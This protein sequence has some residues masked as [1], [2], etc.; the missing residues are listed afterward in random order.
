MDDKEGK[1]LTEGVNEDDEVAAELEAALRYIDK[2]GKI[3]TVAAVLSALSLLC[4][5][6]GILVRGLG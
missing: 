4:M 1:D 6:V 2:T 3:L 5:I